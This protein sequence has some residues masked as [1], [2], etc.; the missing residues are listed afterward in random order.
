M[1]NDNQYTQPD[2]TVGAQMPSRSA[3]R[4]AWNPYLRYREIRGRHLLVDVHSAADIVE[5]SPQLGG[6]FSRSNFTLFPQAFLSWCA[7]FDDGEPGAQ[8]QI[9]ETLSDANLIL[10]W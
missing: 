2:T 4:F 5:I 10:G 1:D 8:G 9:L 7:M 6:L 3:D